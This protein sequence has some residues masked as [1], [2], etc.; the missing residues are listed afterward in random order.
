MFTMLGAEVLPEALHFLN[1]GW[2]LVHLIAIP[3][4][5][6]IGMAVGKSRCRRTHTDTRTPPR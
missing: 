1:W 6:L 2:W 4:M 5:F 3:G